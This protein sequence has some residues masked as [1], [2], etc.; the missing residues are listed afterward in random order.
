VTLTSTTRARGPKK[1]PH[2]FD[3]VK[4]T[5]NGLGRRYATGRSR[6]DGRPSSA[7]ASA[8]TADDRRSADAVDFG[9]PPVGARVTFVLFVADVRVDVD[10]VVTGLG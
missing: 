3:P 1:C 5:A 7:A 4:P 8:G 2:R 6:R 10:E 9:D